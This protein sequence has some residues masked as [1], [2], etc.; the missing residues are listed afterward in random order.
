M[1]SLDFK[2]KISRI[3][4]KPILIGVVDFIFQTTERIVYDNV[5]NRIWNHVENT[6]WDNI[7]RNKYTTDSLECAWS[8]L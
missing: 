4:Y 2:E 1:K 7:M 3:V 6:K 8:N 5:G